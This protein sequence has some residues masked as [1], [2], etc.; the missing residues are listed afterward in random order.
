MSELALW[1]DELRQAIAAEWR[2]PLPCSGKQASERAA[3]VFLAHRAVLRLMQRTCDDPLCP[4]QDGL[5]CHYRDAS[6]GT[7]GWHIP[8]ASKK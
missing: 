2:H 8:G 6:D 3:R 4:C 7:S 1:V 5:A